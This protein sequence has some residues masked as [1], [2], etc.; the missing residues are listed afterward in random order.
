MLSKNEPQSYQKK[1]S[2]HRKSHDKSS[3]QR[4]THNKIKREY[5]TL[6]STCEEDQ[7]VV[8]ELIL[9]DGRKIPIKQ[10]KVD[11]NTVIAYSLNSD[12]VIITGFAACQLVL[13]VQEKTDEDYPDRVRIGY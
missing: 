8:M 9:N 13:S 4:M 5:D 10:I 3:P 1:T 11:P 12:E 7:I 6:S 2:Q